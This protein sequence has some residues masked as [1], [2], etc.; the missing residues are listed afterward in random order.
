[1]IQIRFVVMVDF[2][3]RRRRSG[4]PPPPTIIDRAGDR[5]SSTSMVSVSA[6]R[7][8]QIR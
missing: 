5:L 7:R 3:G 2:L 1:M 6:N 8:H 4:R